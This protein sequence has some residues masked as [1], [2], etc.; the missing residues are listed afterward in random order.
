MSIGT[1]TANKG[2][3]LKGAISELRRRTGLADLRDD[4]PRGRADPA[5]ADASAG[6]TAAT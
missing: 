5:E 3:S 6:T 1:G 2:F 4:P